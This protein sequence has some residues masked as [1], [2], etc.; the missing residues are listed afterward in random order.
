M[1]T[2][3][4]LLQEVHISTRKKDER[5]HSSS[6]VQSFSNVFKRRSSITSESSI[7]SLPTELDAKIRKSK[8]Q[9]QIFKNRKL[10]FEASDLS[11]HPI[12]NLQSTIN[13]LSDKGNN[14]EE[15]TEE[16]LEL[17]SQKKLSGH[18]FL[19]ESSKPNKGKEKDTGDQFNQRRKPLAS[20]RE[21]D[22]SNSSNEEEPDRRKPW[23][24]KSR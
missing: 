9:Y 24:S 22:D 13:V 6:P 4:Q 5:K 21:G 1:H 7:H 15:D 8:G 3:Q 16:I 20:G 10:S 17:N 19:K 12:K 2:N 23:H 14:E 11:K 18:S